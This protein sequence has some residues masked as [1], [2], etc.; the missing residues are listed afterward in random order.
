MNKSCINLYI[1]IE[2]MTLTIIEKDFNIKFIK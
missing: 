2:K 1:S